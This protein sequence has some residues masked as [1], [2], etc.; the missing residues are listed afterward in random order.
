MNIKQ[1]FPVRLGLVLAA[2]AVSFF[3]VLALAVPY[4]LQRAAQHSAQASNEDKVTLFMRVVYPS[5]ADDLRLSPSKAAI[6]LH[7]PA[8]FERV[9]Q[10]IR[11]F[12]QGTRLVK[13]KIFDATGVVVY[14]SD[15]RQIGQPF[16]EQTEAILHA[17]RGRG[18]S[19]V[20]FRERFVGYSG[21]LSDV[22]IVSSYLPIRDDQRNIVG[23]TEIYSERT[24]VF[25]QIDYDRARLISVLVVGFA[26]LGAL[27]VW[28]LWSMYLTVRETIEDQGK[29]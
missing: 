5:I 22:A 2:L 8:V 7:D 23:I 15:P 27:V 12:V 21:E 6:P 3:V 28:V 20:T 17:L 4:A 24:E 11:A 9:D 26:V 25:R 13:V 14:S 16:E 10:E 29:A 19:D 1:I 18:F